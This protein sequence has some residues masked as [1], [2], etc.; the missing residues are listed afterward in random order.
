MGD[1]DGPASPPPG[2]SVQLGN[3]AIVGVIL[4]VAA[5][6]AVSEV[7]SDG[8]PGPKGPAPEALLVGLDGTQRRLSELQGKVVLLNFWATWCPPCNDEMPELVAV[9]KA[10]EPRGVVFVA[11][12][13]EEQP[14]AVRAWLAGHDEVG[15]Y[16]ALTPHDTAEAFGLEALPTTFVIGRDGAVQRAARGRVQGWRVSK[17]LDDAL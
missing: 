7:F 17:W 6:L 8:E 11:A 4:A 5:A 15:P 16:V 12:N 14:A 10:Y 1:E 3:T 9:A 2:R 13:A